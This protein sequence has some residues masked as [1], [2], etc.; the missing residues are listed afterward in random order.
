[1]EWIQEE[2]WKRRNNYRASTVKRIVDDSMLD[3]D[4]LLE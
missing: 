3:D 1:M 4:L 2:T